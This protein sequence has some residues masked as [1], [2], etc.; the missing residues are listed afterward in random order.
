MF[1]FDFNTALKVQCPKNCHF[2]FWQMLVFLITPLYLCRDSNGKIRFFFISQVRP[3]AMD[4]TVGAP[5]L[6][7]GFTRIITKS[8]SGDTSAELRTMAGSF[9]VSLTT[10]RKKSV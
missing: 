8:D 10:K 7:I 4:L 9:H 3:P 5:D 2:C 6:F 1:A